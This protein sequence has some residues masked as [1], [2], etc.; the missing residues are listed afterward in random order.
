ME[1][2]IYL[3]SSAL[4]MFDTVAKYI[5]RIILWPHFLLICKIRTKQGPSLR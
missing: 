5:L 4:A 1:H 3:P 2:L